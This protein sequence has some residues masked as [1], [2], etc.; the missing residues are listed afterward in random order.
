MIVHGSGRIAALG[1]LAVLAIPGTGVMDAAAQDRC[2]A[3]VDQEITRIGLSP[4]RIENIAIGSTMSDGDNA[5]IVGYNAW[6]RVKSCDGTLVI[7]MRRNC[8]V[9]DTYTLKNCEIV[10]VKHSC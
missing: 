3:A 1:V 5:R 4:D 6:V 10:G 8:Q 2:A 7:D 9:R